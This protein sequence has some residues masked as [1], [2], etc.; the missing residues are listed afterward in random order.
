MTKCFLKAENIDRDISRGAL[1]RETKIAANT[2]TK[3]ANKE[4]VSLDVLVRI[5]VALDLDWMM[6]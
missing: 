5:C 6:L 4:N 1:R 2:F 3:I